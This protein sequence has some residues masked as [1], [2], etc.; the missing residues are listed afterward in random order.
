MSCELKNDTKHLRPKYFV[1]KPTF[2][3]DAENPGSGTILILYRMP[4]IIFQYFSSFVLSDS[5]SCEKVWETPFIIFV[6]LA[7]FPLWQL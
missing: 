2:E 7:S 3:H 6:L 4:E 5:T 1:E